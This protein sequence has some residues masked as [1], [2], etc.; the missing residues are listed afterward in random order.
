[1]R[2]TGPSDAEIL[3][4]SRAPHSHGEYGYTPYERTTIRPALTVNSI[5]SGYQ[6]AG[7]K[8]VIPSRAVAKMG[9]RLVPDQD[10]AEIEACVRR[11]IAH[12]TPPAVRSSL[13]FH[14]RAHPAMADRRYP[15]LRAARF[16]YARGFGTPAVFVRSGGTIPVVDTFHTLLGIPTVLMGFGLPDDSIHAP[17]EK[18]SLANFY[19]GISTSIWF[20]T[21]V[22]AMHRATTGSGATA[23]HIARSFAS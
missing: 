7:V 8:A 9:F 10:P 6:G 13:R 14:A 1:M 15:A 16:A 5:N 4:D 12:I 21:A 22:D 23:L 18:F 2:Q 19:R 3:R 20:L 17:N 11:H